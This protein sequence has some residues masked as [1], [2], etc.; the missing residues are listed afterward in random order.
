MG[1]ITLTSEEYADLRSYIAFVRP[2]PMPGY[3]QYLF[4]NSIGRSY[5][6]PSCDLGKTQILLGM[7][8]QITSTQVRHLVE[9]VSHSKY[10]ADSFL[11]GAVNDVLCH[12]EVTA[13]RHYV[14]SDLLKLFSQSNVIRGIVSGK[15]VSNSPI[16]GSL[17][18]LD[19][20]KAQYEPVSSAPDVPEHSDKHSVKLPV[21][22]PVAACSSV[23]DSPPA[24]QSVQHTSSNKVDERGAPCSSAPEVQPSCFHPDYDT[25][26]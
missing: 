5:A 4:L 18:S 16:V 7:A 20:V 25:L 8:T 13:A 14:D 17:Q 22:E 19:P 6:N 23:P 2:A 10:A 11:R 1:F 26:I 15:N 3:E 12:S 24:R 21:Y 9:S